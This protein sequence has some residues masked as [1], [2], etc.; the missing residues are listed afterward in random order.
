MHR[1]RYGT[2]FL[3]ELV[4]RHLGDDLDYSPDDV[5][6]DMYRRA[7]FE[8]G[9]AFNESLEVVCDKFAALPLLFQPGSSWNYS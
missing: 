6:G 4:E 2:L 9:V 7:G 1:Q 3:K 5:G 8:A